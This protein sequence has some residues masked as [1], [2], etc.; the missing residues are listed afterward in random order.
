VVKIGLNLV[1]VAVE[2]PPMFPNR[3]R[4][5]QGIRHPALGGMHGDLKNVVNHTM[6][7]DPI[8]AFIVVSR[9]KNRNK[10]AK[11]AGSLRAYDGTTKFRL[12]FLT[13]INK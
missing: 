4:T 3:T 11:L 6:I 1:Q 2:C 13:C 10:K 12:K 8:L 7:I 9:A 5:R